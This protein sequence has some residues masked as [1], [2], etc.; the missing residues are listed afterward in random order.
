MSSKE[1]SNTGGT[2]SGKSGSGGYTYKSSGTNN[3]V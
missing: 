3:Q 2:G 1:S